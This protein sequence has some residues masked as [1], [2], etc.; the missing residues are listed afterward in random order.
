MDLAPGAPPIARSPYK[1]APNELQKLSTQLQDLL[2]KDSLD[3][4]CRHKGARV[5]FIKRG[6]V[7]EISTK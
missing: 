5:L 4:A 3:R 2:I 6:M 7:I 1:L